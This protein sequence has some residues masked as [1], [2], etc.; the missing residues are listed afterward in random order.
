MGCIPEAVLGDLNYC[1]ISD[2]ILQILVDGKINAA[3]MLEAFEFDI[4]KIKD[5]EWKPIIEKSIETCL[6]L[7]ELGEPKMLILKILTS[8]F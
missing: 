6:K 8:A 4:A 7:S 3:K 5:V 1:C 2:C